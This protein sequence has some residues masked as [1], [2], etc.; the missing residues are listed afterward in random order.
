MEMSLLS[1][2][3]NYIYPCL[4]KVSYFIKMGGG[5]LL[6]PT[7]L[8]SSV[9]IYIEYAKL[10]LH[11]NSIKWSFSDAQIMCGPKND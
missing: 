1:L 6:T 8:N 11:N 2:L 3:I 5:D 10:P 7:P 4:L 9:Y